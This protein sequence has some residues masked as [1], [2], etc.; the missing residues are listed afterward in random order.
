MTAQDLRAGETERGSPERARRAFPER[1]ERRS[2]RGPQSSEQRRAQRISRALG[3]FSVGLGLVEI[4]APRAVTKAIGLGGHGYRPSAANGLGKLSSAALSSLPA[5]VGSRSTPSG[6]HLRAALAFF[7]ARE[8]GNGLAI[9]SQPA[10]SRWL[11]TRVFGDFL[12]LAFLALQARQAEPKRLATAAAA[13]AGVT[14]LDVYAARRLSDA[15]SPSRT[16]QPDGSIRIVESIA[17]RRPPED[18]YSAWRE[19][20]NF[21]HI[22]SHVEAVE[23][24]NDR[25]SHWKVAGPGGTSVE[26][27]AE[28]VA[29]DPHQLLVWRSVPGSEIE[30]EGSVRFQPGPKGRGTLLRVSLRYRPPAGTLGAFVATLFGEEPEIQ[31]RDDLRR[32]KQFLETG[33]ILTTEGQPV[34]PPRGILGAPLRAAQQLKAAAGE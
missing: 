18:C 27:D 24:T 26:W 28:I 2:Y 20:S 32:F 29:D 3:W 10:A 12:D 25:L 8:L 15:H 31:V 1:R 4:G 6:D 34:G 30:N 17:V 9:L 13:V 33:E 5:L 14:A 7:G 23:T 19:L 11:W 21:P 22:M 16:L